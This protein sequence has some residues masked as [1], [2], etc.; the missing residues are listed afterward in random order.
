MGVEEPEEAE[1]EGEEAPCGDHGAGCGWSGADREGSFAGLLVFVEVAEVVDG[2]E[3][4][5]EEAGLEACDEG[6]RCP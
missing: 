5:A 4:R 3:G 1:S 6:M 2:D